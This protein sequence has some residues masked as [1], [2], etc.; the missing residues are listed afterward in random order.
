MENTRRTKRI[1]VRK[2][3]EFWARHHRHH[4]EAEDAAVAAVEA[5]AEVEGRAV[6]EEWDALNASSGRCGGTGTKTM[7]TRKRRNE[8]A[9]RASA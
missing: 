6:P 8:T 9:N 1:R 2:T 4:P 5:V 7:P 3:S